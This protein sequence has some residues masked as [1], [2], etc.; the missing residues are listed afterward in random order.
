L[1]LT[2]RGDGEARRLPLRP[3]VGGGAERMRG[4]KESWGVRVEEEG[5]GR[6]G[7]DVRE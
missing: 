1:T 5:R 4:G 6:D 2:R 3:I 7:E